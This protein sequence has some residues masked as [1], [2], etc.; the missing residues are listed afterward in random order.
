MITIPHIESRDRPL[1]SSQNCG[2]LIASNSHLVP[3]KA[4]MLEHELRGFLGESQ[5]LVDD[6]SLW[7]VP[8]FPI[9]WLAIALPC[10]GATEYL[11]DS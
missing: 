7:L 3:R 10:S 8:F 11:L 2:N 9:V 1:K 6:F 5:D 4:M